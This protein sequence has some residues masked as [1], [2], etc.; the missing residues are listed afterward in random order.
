MLYLWDAPLLSGSSQGPIFLARSKTGQ[1]WLVDSAMQ[2]LHSPPVSARASLAGDGR[3]S[4]E[5]TRG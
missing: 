5:G 2:K 3:E 1:K 4:M